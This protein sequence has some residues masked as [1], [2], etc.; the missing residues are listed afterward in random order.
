MDLGGR[1][2]PTGI[3]LAAGAAR[4]FGGDKLLVPL[5]G[6]TSVGQAA[7]RAMHSALGHVVAVVRPGDDA[8][9]SALA[10]CGATIVHC[11]KAEDG[12]GASLA[13]GVSATADAQGWVVALAD[14]PWVAPATIRAVADAIAAGASL[15]APYHRG[16]RGHPVGFASGHRESLLALAGDEGARALLEHAGASL[17]RIDVDDPGVLRDVDTPADLAER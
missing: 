12:I 6:G 16:Q 8:L 15:S 17:V 9:A 10:A 1:A 3:L 5:A 13:C 2:P 7:C 14:M 11:P 4:R